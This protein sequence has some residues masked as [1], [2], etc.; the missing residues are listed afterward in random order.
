[1]P[2]PSIVQALSFGRPRKSVLRVGIEHAATDVIQVRVRVR[3][4]L[5][6]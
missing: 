4:G 6:P 3:S 5:E 1:M 2:P